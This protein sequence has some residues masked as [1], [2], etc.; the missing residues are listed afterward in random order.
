MCIDEEDGLVFGSTAL[1]FTFG[2]VRKPVNRLC[3]LYLL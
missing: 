1:A 2:A 3:G